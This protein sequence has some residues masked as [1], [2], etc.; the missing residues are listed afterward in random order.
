MRDEDESHTKFVPK[1]LRLVP[2]V[3]KHLVHRRDTPSCS[4][5]TSSFQQR[6]SE[7]FRCRTRQQTAPPSV[8][9]DLGA[10]LIL[11]ADF[12]LCSAKHCTKACASLDHLPPTSPAITTILAL[13]PVTVLG[14]CLPSACERASMPLHWLRSSKERQ[15]FCNH[16]QPARIRIPLRDVQVSHRDVGGDW[17]RLSNRSGRQ[18]SP[19]HNL[20]C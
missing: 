4:W 19:W 20:S 11:G 14:T 16:L 17:P 6:S 15:T 2:G 8:T 3:T 12:A 5:V 7:R 9:R 18:Y 13:P 1:T 10:R